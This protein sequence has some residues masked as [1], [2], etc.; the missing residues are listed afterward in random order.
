MDLEIAR[1]FSEYD[2]DLDDVDDLKDGIHE[3]KDIIR[4]FE[5]AHIDLRRV[6]GEHRY[7]AENEDYD[8]MVEQ[9]TDWLKNA[10]T[11]ISE[12]KKSAQEELEQR[13]QKKR[14][15]ELEENKMQER[16]QLQARLEIEEKY[17][18]IKITQFLKTMD[19]DHAMHIVI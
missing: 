9:M 12:K 2:L 13:D 16:L 6:L 10:K 3:L 11:S 5:S 18:C 14:L 7:D 1:F 4:R 15:A 19:I 17:L 8:A